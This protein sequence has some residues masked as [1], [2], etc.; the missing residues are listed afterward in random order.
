MRTVA[1]RMAA[2]AQRLA[3]NGAVTRFSR[4]GPLSRFLSQSAWI[5]FG[6]RFNCFTVSGTKRG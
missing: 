3:P 5:A 1:D 4:P 2:L 6:L